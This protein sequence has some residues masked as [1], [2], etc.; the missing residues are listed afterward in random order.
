MST[1]NLPGV[2]RRSV[3]KADNLAAIFEPIVYKMCEPRR[4][5]TLQA[6]TAIY[7]VS[8]TFMYVCVSVCLPVYVYSECRS[9]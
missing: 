5:T 1:W 3:R 7:K 6:S 9:E 8:F 4:L 2:K